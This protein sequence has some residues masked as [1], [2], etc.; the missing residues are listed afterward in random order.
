MMVASTAGRT[1]SWPD[2]ATEEKNCA[3]ASMQDPGRLR[4]EDGTCT[5]H[6]GIAKL[7]RELFERL[8]LRPERSW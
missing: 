5:E 1:E 3:P 4:I 7:I 2:S 8:E 6:D